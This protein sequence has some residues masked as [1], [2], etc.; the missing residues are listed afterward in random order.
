MNDD[1]KPEAFTLPYSDHSI[2][3]RLRS[4]IDDECEDDPWLANLLRQAANRIEQLTAK[5]L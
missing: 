2:V 4:V 3:I 1:S 5:Q